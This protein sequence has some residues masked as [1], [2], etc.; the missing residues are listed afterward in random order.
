MPRQRAHYSRRAY[1]FPDD[2]PQRL[3]WFKHASGLPWAEIARRPWGYL[4]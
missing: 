1:P 4:P 2:L 3:G